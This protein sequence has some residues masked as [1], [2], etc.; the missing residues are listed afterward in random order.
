MWSEACLTA[1][2]LALPLTNSST[3]SMKYI[4][5]FNLWFNL[6][7]PRVHLKYTIF[8]LKNVFRITRIRKSNRGSRKSFYVVL[9]SFFLHISY[10]IDDNN[11]KLNHQINSYKKDICSFVLN[12][13]DMSNPNLH[14]ILNV[15]ISYYKLMKNIEL[16]WLLISCVL[17]FLLRCRYHTE[18]IKK[19]EL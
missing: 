11:T 3:H 12:N 14:Y 13:N 19:K 16:L 15:L 2:W 17:P 18:N 7:L 9:N 1:N 6:L 8:R 5:T 4:S 10:G